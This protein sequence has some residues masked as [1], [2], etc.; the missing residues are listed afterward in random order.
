LVGKNFVIIDDAEAMNHV[1]QNA[2]LKLL[3]E[4][5]DSIHFILTSHSPDRLLPTIRSRA[6]TFAV[7]AIDALESRRLLKAA[8][9]AEPLTEQRLL[10]VAEGLPAE[11]TRL[12]ESDADFRELSE[13]V[14]T[15]RQFVEGTTY[16]R[17]V[18]VQTLK[19]DRYATLQL[20]ETIFLLLRRSLAKDPDRSRVRLIGRLIEASEHIRA[21]G[22]V[23]LQLSDAVL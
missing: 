20:L 14:Q 19:E 10:Y 17:L 18:L 22:N 6:Q 11:L 3:E 9:I 8:G 7:P 4:P 21:N 5:N 1:A 15:A 12:I 23:K 13:R 2:L 16:Q